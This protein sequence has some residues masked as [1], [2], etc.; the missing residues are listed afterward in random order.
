MMCIKIGNANIINQTFFF[1][2]IQKSK[3]VQPTR[4]RIV[5]CMELHQINCFLIH[6]IKSHLNCASY[7]IFSYFSWLRNPF[8]KHLNGVLFVALIFT[9][10]SNYFARAIVV[11]HVKCSESSIDIGIQIRS[12]FWKIELLIF[13]FHISNLP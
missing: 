7:L 11:C 10:S 12:S 4:I 6:S 1:Q 2:F 9:N 3:P 5:P 8:S 13:F